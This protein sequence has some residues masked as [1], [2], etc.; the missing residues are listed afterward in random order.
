MWGAVRFLAGIILIAASFIAQ[1]TMSACATEVDL[2]L[3][4]A[5][6]VS[7]SVDDQ[8]FALQREGY[9]AA[10]TSPRVIEAIRS[11]RAWA[12]CDLLH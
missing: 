3:A 7:G 4:L 11:G 9:S 6:D 2:L 5:A 12:H 8:K 1:N 10:I